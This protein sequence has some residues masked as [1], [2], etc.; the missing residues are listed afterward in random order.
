MARS[1]LC[2]LVGAP[3]L[4][5]Y[6]Q[7]AQALRP[8]ARAV[9]LPAE[10]PS[11]SLTTPYLQALGKAQLHGYPA[12]RPRSLELLTLLLAHPEGITG[13]SLARAL[14][15][16]PNPQALRS[17][18]CRLRQ[19]GFDIPSRPYRLLSPIEA[20]FLKLQEALEQNQLYQA[21]A[22]YQG[23]LLPRS[24]AP[25]IEL[26]RHRIEEQ[27]RQAVLQQPDPE[28]LYRL[29]Q[30]IP[31][32]LLL[33]ETLLHRLSPQDPRYPAVWAWVKRLSAQYR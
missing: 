22:L 14:Y 31:D 3:L 33:W 16:E 20:D 28:L 24:Q 21:L 32:D 5:P 12:L 2:A 6:R 25:G 13:E 29:V 1:H 8:E 15:P 30:R 17:E 9:F 18:L 23:P 27:L 26:L 10:L 7:M 4:A 11:I 19:Q